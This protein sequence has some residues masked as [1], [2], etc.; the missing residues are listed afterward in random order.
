MSGAHTRTEKIRS[1]ENI[2]LRIVK[3]CSLIAVHGNKLSRCSGW[4]ACQ[5]ER[6]REEQRHSEVSEMGVESFNTDR[7]RA[8][9]GRVAVIAKS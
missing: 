8:A 6:V 7:L 2:K 1:R 9:S 4:L 5:R 3:E